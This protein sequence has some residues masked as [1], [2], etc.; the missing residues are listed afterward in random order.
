MNQHYFKVYDTLTPELLHYYFKQRDPWDKPQRAYEIL[1]ANK[2]DRLFRYVFYKYFMSTRSIDTRKIFNT[3]KN[4][5]FKFEHEDLFMIDNDTLLLNVH[6]KIYLIIRDDLFHAP[7]FTPKYFIP[8]LPGVFRKCCKTNF[9]CVDYY[10]K[11]YTELVPDSS[12]TYINNS[13]DLKLYKN[14]WDDHIE[15]IK[16]TY[17]KSSY[18]NNYVNT[19]KLFTPDCYQGCSRVGVTIEQNKHAYYCAVEYASEVHRTDLIKPG[20]I[21]T[22]KNTK[23]T[24]SDLV[25]RFGKVNYQ[26]LHNIFNI[27][28][29][30]YTELTNSNI[31]NMNELLDY[32]NSSYIFYT[33]TEYN[34]VCRLDSLIKK[35]KTIQIKDKVEKKQPWWYK[36]L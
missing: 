7:K 10:N 32:V 5:N 33:S 13:D 8:N 2:G 9:E 22:I 26:V 35:D 36:F 21:N 6:D 4:I 17:S 27:D 18:F 31:S 24:L 3:Y 12:K 29:T 23:L 11:L 19:S 30:K 34:F 25:N 14:L 15:D 16:W 1:L 20:I 28:C